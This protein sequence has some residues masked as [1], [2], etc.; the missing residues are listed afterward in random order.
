MVHCASLNASYLLTDIYAQISM[1]PN[2][3]EFTILLT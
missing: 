1:S 2:Q 3:S